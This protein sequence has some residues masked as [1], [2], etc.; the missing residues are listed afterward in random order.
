LSSSEPLAE[1]IIDRLIADLRAL[2]GILYPRAAR[3]P[4]PAAAPA[5]AAPAPAPAGRAV[6]R[7]RLLIPTG[8]T[9]TA[10]GVSEVVAEAA[11]AVEERPVLVA[12]Y[13]K[14]LPWNGHL[15]DTAPG[16]ITNKGDKYDFGREVDYVMVV[17]TIDTQIEFDR[18]VN[19]TTPVVSGGT[20]FDWNL[21]V[22][23]V[24]Y[25][26]VSATL[27]GQLYVFAAWWE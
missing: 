23:E 13:V 26:G 14:E 2:R 18:P 19:P 1:E 12:R 7:Q 27:E 24:Y 22:R 4:T 20:A 16:A 10:A 25:K 6:P 8:E 3:P 21:R 17:P 5:A 15:F 9:G 11:R